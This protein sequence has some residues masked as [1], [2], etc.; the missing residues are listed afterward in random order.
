MFALLKKLLLSLYNVL[1]AFNLDAPKP[2]SHVGLPLQSSFFP[3]VNLIKSKKYFLL[4][5]GIII[6]FNAIFSYIFLLLGISWLYTIYAILFMVPFALLVCYG[7]NKQYIY[8]ASRLCINILCLITLG[9]L[10]H[11][12][13]LSFELG[14]ICCFISLC[15][16]PL[17]GSYSGVYFSRIGVSAFFSDFFPSISCLFNPEA[18]SNSGSAS[19]TSSSV[20]DLNSLTRPYGWSVAGL[21]GTT[22]EG[23]KEERASLMDSH[24][25]LKDAT[26]GKPVNLIVR[27]LN[28][29]KYIKYCIGD[30]PTIKNAEVQVSNPFNSL[31]L[32]QAMVKRVISINTYLKNNT[33]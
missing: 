27:D 33:Q 6:C 9:I 28:G 25:L 21:S 15:I 30:N 29:Q 10:K 12:G 13:L 23:L 8:T 5:L 3:F 11:F 24:K 18:G 31:E 2:Y 14:I 20:P 26:P 22:L 16:V 1:D 17:L 32:R 7:L 19:A 4:C